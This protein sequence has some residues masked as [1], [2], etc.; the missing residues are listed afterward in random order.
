MYA[1]IRTGL[2]PDAMKRNGRGAEKADDSRVDRGAEEPRT[3]T[4]RRSANGVSRGVPVRTPSVRS[5]RSY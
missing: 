5:A 2:L 3:E 4:A 1:S